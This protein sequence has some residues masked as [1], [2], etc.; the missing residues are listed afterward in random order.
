MPRAVSCVAM[1]PAMCV[2]ADQ[3][4]TQ[5]QWLWQVTSCA[6]KHTYRASCNAW[7]KNCKLSRRRLWASKQLLNCA[8][9]YMMYQ[10]VFWCI[11]MLE[12]MSILQLQMHLACNRALLIVFAVQSRSWQL[13][14]WTA[15]MQLSTK[16][17]QACCVALARRI[18]RLP[19]LK[20]YIGKQSRQWSTRIC[21][22]LAYHNSKLH[23]M[24]VWVG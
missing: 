8:M 2:L 1:K 13:G 12:R 19:Q 24:R 7:P 9:T 21:C 6:D 5:W 16:P 4:I 14:V 11:F 23:M 15:T 3:I 22:S 18:C 10:I 17:C 20:S